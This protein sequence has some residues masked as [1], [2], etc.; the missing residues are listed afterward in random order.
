MYELDPGQLGQLEAERY[1]RFGCRD[2]LLLFVELGRWYWK[3]R[4]VEITCGRALAEK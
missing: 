4:S 1:S 2:L 3:V